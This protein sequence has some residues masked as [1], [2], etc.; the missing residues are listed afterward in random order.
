MTIEDLELVATMLLRLRQDRL[1]S[2]VLLCVGLAGLDE[3]EQTVQ[4]RRQ[5]AGTG[6]AM[7]M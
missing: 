4:D 1:L 5:D 3:D 2:E 7:V 6:T